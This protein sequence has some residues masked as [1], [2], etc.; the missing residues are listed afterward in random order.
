MYL[1]KIRNAIELYSFPLTIGELSIDTEQ[2]L[3]VTKIK[4][5]R[6]FQAVVF[7]FFLMVQKLLQVFAK[8]VWHCYDRSFKG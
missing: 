6:L 5:S 3:K 1:M 2:H 8:E 4:T 7:I